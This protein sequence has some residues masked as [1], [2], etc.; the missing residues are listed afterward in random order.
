MKKEKKISEPEM[1]GEYNFNDGIRGKY[2]ER[3]V[4]G[5]NIVILSPDVA[6]VFRD[7]ESVNEALRLLIK[8]SHQTNPPG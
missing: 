2:A 1:L 6:E 7:S 5:T 3:F 4:E 8:I